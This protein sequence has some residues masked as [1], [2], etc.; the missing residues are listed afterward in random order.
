MIEGV[1]P[2]GVVWSEAL[3]DPPE[4]ALLPEEEAL[5]A[6]ASEKRRREFTV[7]RHCARQA[8]SQLGLRPGAVLSGPAGDP[9]WPAGVVGSITHCAGYRGA[10][11]AWAADVATIGIDAEPHEPLP[12]GV[13]DAVAL[14]QELAQMI[15]ELA[16]GTP[17]ICWDRV[18]FS[19]KEAVY[20][21]WYPHAR[22]MLGFEQAVLT[23]GPDGTLSAHLLVP[24]SQAQGFTGRWMV[25]G[26]LV[27]TA[28]TQ[29]VWVDAGRHPYSARGPKIS[30]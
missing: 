13:L 20:K 4:A 6:R 23:I 19:G 21:A 22:R 10:A 7:G 8:L 29:V 1:L 12:D 27:L 24:G 28:I 26:G 9:Q 15:R 11:V 2:S 14:P 18:L 17:D 30:T 5:M 3:D 25:D 16:D